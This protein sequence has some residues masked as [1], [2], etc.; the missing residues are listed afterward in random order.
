MTMVNSITEEE[1]NNMRHD[2][3]IGID[4]KFFGGDALK[5]T[6]ATFVEWIVENNFQLIFEEDE[7]PEK[8]EL[9]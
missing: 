1:W 6:I 2:V 5:I 8:S 4:K 7:I 9:H 3:V